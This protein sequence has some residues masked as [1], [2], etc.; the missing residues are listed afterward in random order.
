MSKRVAER[1][2][3]D[4]NWDQ[5]D[6]EEENGGSSF[7]GFSGFKGFQPAQ[8][9]T[10]FSFGTRSLTNGKAET[11]KSETSNIP[12][13]DQSP[14]LVQ[15][16][17]TNG[18]DTGTADKKE[19]NTGVGKEDS[20]KKEKQAQYVQNL[21][22]LNESVLSWIK[23]HVEKNPYCIL[24]PIFSDYDKHLKEIEKEAEVSGKKVETDVKTSFQSK[25]KDSPAQS[26][27][28]VNSSS[29]MDKFKPPSG[30][31]TCDICLVS[32]P[33]DKVKCL[34]CE[35]PKPGSSK[36]EEKP[37]SGFK[38]GAN[39]FGS[40]SSFKFNTNGSTTSSASPATFSFGSGT[41]SSSNCTS[42]TN[43]FSFGTVTTAQSTG[44][45]SFGS[46]TN[47]K[48]FT[49]QTSSTS[50]D[51]K[52]DSADVKPAFSF[53]TTTTT[54]ENKTLSFGSSTTTAGTTSVFGGT[55]SSPS[56]K[57]FSFGST[58]TSTADPKTFSFGLAKPAE[59]SDKEDSASVTANSSEEKNTGDSESK[60]ADTGS[61]TSTGFFGFNFKP[62]NNLFGNS[63]TS[64]NTSGFSF[65]VNSS[66]QPSS[67][68]N[69]NEE[70]EYVP[71]P[72]ESVEVKEEGALYTI[73]C[74]MFYQK[75][76]AWEERGL[77][78]LHLKKSNEKL[79]LL[80]RTDT[81]LGN[82]LLNISI[83]ATMP[84]KRQGKN[85]VS[86]FAVPNPPIKGIDESKPVPWLIRVK[87]GQDADQLVEKIDEL[88]KE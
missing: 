21:K 65:G 17:K 74:K 83:P 7:S 27:P 51:T 59:K 41:S 8:T 44:N 80:V 36:P 48:P 26:V 29:F 73:K 16:P 87:T 5:E 37:S 15:S 35:T 39:A 40:S 31:W 42:G 69:T 84:V 25:G 22:N 67:T 53:G 28:S 60:K 9:S 78:F 19:S 62:G 23:Q 11:Q 63:G 14:K 12:K 3:T 71:P 88:R 49:F 72:V 56:G 2:L 45:F 55:K 85:N 61:V 20:V 77:G 13:L 18:K 76:G 70:E 58:T 57:S 79:Q 10:P 34:A 43:K 64:S 68:T 4:R 24:T 66:A 30:S 82:I 46:S 38:I 50:A 75:Y 33:G 1:E 6:E 81:A 47:S 86:L 54:A 52:S 32:N